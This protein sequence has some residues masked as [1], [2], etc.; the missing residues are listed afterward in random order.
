MSRTYKDLQGERRFRAVYR[1]EALAM[2]LQGWLS[3]DYAATV[4]RAFASRAPGE[5]VR[6]VNEAGDVVADLPAERVR[7]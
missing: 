5:S 4:E 2:D 7:R 1:D 6:I 3:D